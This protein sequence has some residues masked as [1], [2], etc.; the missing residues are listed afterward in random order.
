MWLRHNAITDYLERVDVGFVR[1]NLLLFIAFLP[2]PARLFAEFIG[3]NR[4]D[5]PSRIPH[6]VFHAPSFM[7]P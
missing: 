6:Q 7:I 3:M 1:L 4:P 2:F 5:G